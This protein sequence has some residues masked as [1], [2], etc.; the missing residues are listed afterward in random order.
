MQPLTNE[1]NQ[2]A[3]EGA[4]RGATAACRRG[5]RGSRLIA[6]GRLVPGFDSAVALFRFVMAPEQ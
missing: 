2:T 6:I 3:L 1:N 5:T 4:D